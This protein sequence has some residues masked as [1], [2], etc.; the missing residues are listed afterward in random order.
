MPRFIVLI[1]IS[2]FVF[3]SC[4]DEKQQTTKSTT[5]TETKKVVKHYICLNNC[6]NSGSDN[7]GNC[8]ECNEP[9][10]HNTAYHSNDLLKTGPLKVQS[11]ATQ[12]NS[13]TTTVRPP[14]PAQNA[15]GVYHYTCTNGC[16]GGAGTATKCVACGETL[17]HN[18]A[19][20]N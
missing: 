16:N 17:A 4:K 2:L 13:N 5:T 10:T 1:F 3:V 12:P 19:Y 14:E 6:E 15:A 11:N 8:K 18:Q 20:H 9:L 7:A